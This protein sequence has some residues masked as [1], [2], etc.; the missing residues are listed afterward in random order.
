MVKI[1]LFL[2]SFM[3][4]VL[5]FSTTA[6]SGYAKCEITKYQYMLSIL[7]TSQLA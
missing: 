1:D 4:C 6:T 5:Q 2:C 7:V 3:R